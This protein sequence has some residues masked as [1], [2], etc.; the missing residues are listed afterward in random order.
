MSVSFKQ[1]NNKINSVRFN[2]G[3]VWTAISSVIEEITGDAPISLDN[4][5]KGNITELIQYG[6]CTQAGTPTPSSPID[7]KCNNGTLKA[8]HQSGLPN[9]YTLLDCVGGNGSQYVITDVYLS[10]TDVVECEYRNSSTTGYGAIYGI[11]KNSDSSAL[12]GNQTYYCYDEANNKVDSDISV[13]TEWHESRHDFVNGTLTIDGAITS[14]TPWEFTNSTKNA[15]LSRYY[16]GSYGY[17]WKGYIRKFKVTRGNEVV[18]DLLP[19]KDSSDVAGLYDLVTSTFYT[20]TGGALLEGN[21]VDD[22]EIVVVGTPEV[23]T[24]SATGATSQTVSVPNLFGVDNRKDTIDI[25]SGEI[26]RTCGVLVL[27]GT[28]NWQAFPGNQY[29]SLYDIEPAGPI[30]TRAPQNPRPISTHFQHETPGDP[31]FLRVSGDNLEFYY[32]EEFSD[33]TTWK[34]WLASQY[35]AATPVIMVYK[36]YDEYTEQTTPKRLRTAEGTNT[37]SVTAEVEPIYLEA[38]YSQSV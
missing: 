9:G 26:S 12:Y 4:A 23:L 25:I 7:I 28:E 21:V 36:L 15:V 29:F 14:F 19:C 37:I 35:A 32:D 1:P 31:P 18:C 11:Y 27:D 3:L 6:L 5:V 20:P 8:R 13:D 24:V 22:I 30:P 16:N 38:K 10:S 17:N 2:E 34:A 33:L